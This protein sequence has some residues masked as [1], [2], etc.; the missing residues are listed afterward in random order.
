M[1]GIAGI[2]TFFPC[3]GEKEFRLPKRRNLRSR[4]FLKW[5][6]EVTNDD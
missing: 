6:D 4:I 1:D 3:G 2:S 5:N